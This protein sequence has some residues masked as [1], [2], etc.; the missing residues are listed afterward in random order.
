M[1]EVMV[2][3]KI[4]IVDVIKSTIHYNY[5]IICADGKIIEM[6]ESSNIDIPED[7]KVLDLEGKYVIPGLIDAHVHLSLP[8]VDDYSGTNFKST[9]KKY[10]RHAYLTIQSGVTTVREMPGDAYGMLKFRKKIN[11][12]KIIGPRI[13]VSS[14]ALAAPFGYFSL[15][16]FINAPDIIVKIIRVFL[17]IKGVSVDV[18]N[19]N[20]VSLR[21]EKFKKDGFDFI[22]T[23][24]TGKEE[25][26][27]RTKEASS[28]GNM[29]AETLRA[30][31]I[32]AHEK[33]MRVAAHN[34]CLP[35]GFKKAVEAGVDSIEHTP[36]GLVE[37]ETFLNMR[38]K[39]IFWVPTTFA[40]LN[41]RQLVEK[42]ALYDE[43]QFKSAVYEPYH[44]H[45]K[46]ALTF[47]HQ[48][49]EEGSAN[50][51]WKY[52]YEEMQNYIDCYLP[53]NI[54]NA[55]NN[56][57]K[58]VAGTD[59]GAGGAG[60]VPHGFL[61]KE[62]ETLN[63]NGMN[64]YDVLRAATINAAHLLDLAHQIGSIERNKLAD[65]VVLC[66]NPIENLSSIRDIVYVIKEGKIVYHTSHS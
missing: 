66:A 58:I 63:L 61:Y 16:R 15:K 42:P 24:T 6:G 2:L 1:K 25:D 49:L 11:K 53:Q 35:D 62:L 38:E 19:E 26:A 54:K 12:G 34:I 4:N 29:Q 9:Y 22:K 51:L 48:Q 41:W 31:A 60:Y 50:P 28:V 55:I 18:E 46:K 14:P 3:N 43:E 30:I 52:F 36:L 45:G 44:S 23:T 57:V 13:L 37:Y 5:T 10:K 32:K 47:I 20:E 21:I 33:G 65:M 7:A 64:T 39:E 8:G 17:G 27:L 59:A 56:K 40:F